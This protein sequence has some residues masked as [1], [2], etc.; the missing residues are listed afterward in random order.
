MTDYLVLLGND[1]CRAFLSLIRRCEGAN[2]NTLFGGGAFSGWADH[3]RQRVT[4][5]SGGRPLTSTAAGAY[6]FLSST[7]DETAR[8]MKLTGFSPANQ[9][10]AAVGR[11]A[12]RG[13][14]ADV[15]AGRFD[16]AVTKLAYEWASLPGSPY[17]QPVIS[18]ATARSVYVAAGGTIQGV[19]LA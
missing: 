12:A 8:A 18:A 14:L 13:A 3:P 9:D 5:Q 4:R 16:A 15:L 17:G 1:H 11:I 2:Y 10:F 19:V 6:Q 7:W